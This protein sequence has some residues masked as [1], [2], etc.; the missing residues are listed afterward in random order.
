MSEKL[1]TGTLRTKQTN[2]TRTRRHTISLG[3]F[4][5]NVNTIENDNLILC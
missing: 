5:P 2:K 3:S 4:I 1:L